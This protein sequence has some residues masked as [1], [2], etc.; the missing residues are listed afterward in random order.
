MG[1][2]LFS[3][4]NKRA[5]EGNVDVLLK[6]NILLNLHNM[7]KYDAIRFAGELLV[8][9]GCVDEAYIDAMIERE[10]DL[11]TYIGCGVAIPHGVGKAKEFIKK[12]GIV[13]LQFP[14]GVDFDGQKA[15]LVIGIAGKGDEHLSI[16]ANVAT[17]ISEDE[18]KLK[19]LIKTNDVDFIYSTFTAK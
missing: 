14:D 4:K 1:L 10:N 18:E 6:E 16:L 8:K 2:N 5:D 13:I 15:Y 11:T 12:S 3:S 9:S 19:E 7:D 17:I